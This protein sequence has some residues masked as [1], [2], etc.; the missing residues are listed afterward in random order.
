MVLQFSRVVLFDVLESAQCTLYGEKIVTQNVN[1]QKV[2]CHPEQG[3][4][5]HHSGDIIVLIKQRSID[6]IG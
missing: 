3:I 6:L 2:M 1:L 5:Q 4:H